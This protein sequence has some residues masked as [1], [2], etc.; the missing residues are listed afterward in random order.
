MVL[1]SRGLWLPLYDA[2]LS[3]PR[4]QYFQQLHH[5]ISLISLPHPQ[6]RYAA[7][8]LKNRSIF[9]NPEIRDILPYS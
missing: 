5:Q 3:L 8:S 4:I 6:T 9:L 7:T 2:Q 1:W